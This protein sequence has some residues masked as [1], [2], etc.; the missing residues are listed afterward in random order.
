MAKFCPHCGNQ[1]SEE[2][3][4]LPGLRHSRG[5]P[6]ASAQ[7]KAERGLAADSR[8]TAEISQD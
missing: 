1:L 4:I 3:K 2:E 7:P 5:K 6:A 8:E